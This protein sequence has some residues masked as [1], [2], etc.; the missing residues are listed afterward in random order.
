[1]NTSIHQIL[2]LSVI[3]AVAGLAFSGCMTSS[4]KD[5]TTDGGN[6]VVFQE[7]GNMGAVLNTSS[8]AK[9]ATVPDLVTGDLVITALH[10]DSTCGGKGPCFVRSAQ[11][12]NTVGFERLRED[13]IILDSAG[14]R[15]TVFRPGHATT[16]SHIRHVTRLYPNTG[17]EIDIYIS[18][19]LTRGG[20]GDSVV[21]SSTGTITGSLNGT[22]FKSKTFSIT[23][24][25]VPGQGFRPPEGVIDVER[26]RFDVRINFHGGD[27]TC[28]VTRNGAEVR[29]THMDVDGNES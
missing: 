8:L 19:T 20:A 21:F 11:F 3:A 1:M 7:A 16:I 18:T 17:K 27:A 28:D 15:L 24:T 29:T 6:A 26:G 13:T 23:R 12:T 14:M 9:T 10:L 22:E 25:F 5:P 4:Q 2:K